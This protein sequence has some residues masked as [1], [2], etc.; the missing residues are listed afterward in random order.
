MFIFNRTVH[1]SF[2]SMSEVLQNKNWD[3]FITCFSFQYYIFIT[4]NN[5]ITFLKISPIFYQTRLLLWFD[6]WVSIKNT[7]GGI[8]VS[9]LRCYWKL[10]PQNMEPRGVL[11]AIGRIAAEHLW[12]PNSFFSSFFSPPGAEKLPATMA[13]ANWS[14]TEISVTTGPASCFL[15]INCLRKCCMME[16]WLTDY[17]QF[18]YGH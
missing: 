4:L 5:S 6:S 3:S 1:I 10:E 12:M 8:L 9:S 17:F 14:W 13:H 11:Y 18:Q 2:F 7:R 15:S 16:S